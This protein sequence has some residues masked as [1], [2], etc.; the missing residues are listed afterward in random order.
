MK[1]DVQ[2]KLARRASHIFIFSILKESCLY[3]GASADRC[4][5]RAAR[6]ARGLKQW[7]MYNITA[8][9]WHAM[10]I[11]LLGLWR[12]ESF[13]QIDERFLAKIRGGQENVRKMSLAGS[14][15]WNINGRS[16]YYP[17]YSSSCFAALLQQSGKL[18]PLAATRQ[19]RWPTTLPWRESFAS[20][21]LEVQSLRK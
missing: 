19:Q 7:N 18:H 9:P 12:R 20:L 21:E 3:K 6:R 2:F 14:C 13:E 8:N 10:N 5:A 16:R 4:K 17:Q 1:P 11:I 15:A